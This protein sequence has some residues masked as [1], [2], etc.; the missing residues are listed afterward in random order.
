MPEVDVVAIKQA[1]DERLRNEADERILAAMRTYDGPLTRKGFPKGRPLQTH[2]GFY[3][4]G[5]DKR[6]LWPGR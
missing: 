3:I 4:S 1:A 6:R 2:A 5:A